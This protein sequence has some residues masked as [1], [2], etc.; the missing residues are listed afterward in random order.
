[1][2]KKIVCAVCAAAMMISVCGCGNRSADTDDGVPTLVWFVPGDSQRDTAAVM[3]EV[4]KLI[5]P[6]IGAKLDL[7]MI[8]EGAFS[9]KMSMK[10]ASDEAFDLCFTGYVNQYKSG[11]DVGGFL[12][13]TD[14]IEKY[15][16]DLKKDLPDYVLESAKEKGGIYA[17]PNMQVMAN[18]EGVFFFEEYANKY[19]IK[20]GAEYKDITEME[21][22]FEK[23]KQDYPNVYP[24]A[25]SPVGQYLFDYSVV[26]QKPN[27]YVSD[28]E[29]NGYKLQSALDMKEYE[30]G[31][32]AAKSWYDKGYLRS[33][34]DTAVNNRT[35]DLRAGKYASFLGRWKPGIEDDHKNMYGQKTVFV[36]S[37]SK[38][39]TVAR[40]TMT[41]ISRTSKNPEKAMQFLN[42]INTDKELYNLICYGIEGKHYEKL[43]G[44]YIRPIENSGY[45]QLACWKFGNQF[46]AYLLEGQEPDIWEQT[47]KL[48]DSAS[49]ASTF[50]FSFDETPV[51]SEEA[52]CR[53]IVNEYN[54]ITYGSSDYTKLLSEYKSR[55]E[56]AGL[57]RI[58]EEAQR[59]LDEWVKENK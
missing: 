25:D 1:M 51:K 37:G 38:R 35:E 52:Q 53:A 55:L 29:E 19:G 2:I 3:E 54:G 17:I 20:S 42:L 34:I 23:V 28:K 22:Y 9:E 6:K 56:N 40:D 41:A 39:L 8:D 57:D 4:N 15:G 30:Q 5:E 58:I 31:L 44:E 11:I 49:K 50:G 18:V 24:V 45:R 32:K 36:S 16:Q 13:L 26:N 10:M 46:N 27:V 21:P 33:D 14:L 43:D 7:K 48:N 59:Q 47:R 12:E